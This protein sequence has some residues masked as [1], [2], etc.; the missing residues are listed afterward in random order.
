MPFMKR[1]QCTVDCK[2]VLCCEL[3]Y[4]KMLRSNSVEL[5][6]IYNDDTNFILRRAM[7]FSS[8]IPMDEWQ[9]DDIK[10]NVY[11]ENSTLEDTSDMRTI[12]NDEH[13]LRSK[14]AGNEMRAGKDIGHKTVIYFGDTNQRE[15][16]GKVKQVP[17]VSKCNENPDISMQSRQDDEG[18]ASQNFV[19]QENDNRQNLMMKN[20]SNAV[21]KI[22]VNVSPSR[23]D[24]LRIEEDES[25]IE[26]YWS[27]PGDTSGF[28]AD[29]SFV[30][31]WRL[32]G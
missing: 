21:H 8:K 20:D 3:K 25:Q 23:E 14:I 1:V 16:D 18:K 2:C 5:S 32:R 6:S 17:L 30:Q 10:Q 24:V 9:E 15:K 29:W 27:L 26:D 11:E 12:A 31:Q 7:P 19:E 22:V 13:D 4:C 28:K